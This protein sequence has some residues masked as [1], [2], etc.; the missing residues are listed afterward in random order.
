M[1]FQPDL[2]CLPAKL[3]QTLPPFFVSDLYLIDLGQLHRLHR[4]ERVGAKKHPRF[5]FLT[6]LANSKVGNSKKYGVDIQRG[7]SPNKGGG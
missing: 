2:E 4:F 1:L 5:R 6:N 7:F 3:H